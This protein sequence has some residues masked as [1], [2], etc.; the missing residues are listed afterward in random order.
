MHKKKMAFGN[1]KRGKIA[2]L[3]TKKHEWSQ[4]KRGIGHT[5]LGGHNL[6]KTAKGKEKGKQKNPE[7]CVH[8]LLSERNKLVEKTHKTAFILNI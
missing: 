2:F 1:F 7:S 6:S 3:Y 4:L 5:F 8:Y